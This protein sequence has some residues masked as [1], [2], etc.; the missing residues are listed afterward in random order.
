M[1]IQLAQISPRKIKLAH[2]IDF[3]LAQQPHF[4]RNRRAAQVLIQRGQGQIA[5]QG[6]FEIGGVVE[7]E[8]VASGEVEGC[9][10]GLLIGF[11]I[12]LN[13]KLCQVGQR[14][15]AKIGGVAFSSYSHLQNI[16]DFQTPESRNP[17]PALTEQIEYFLYGGGG[18][19]AVHPCHRDRTIE[20]QAHLGG[21]QVTAGLDHAVFLGPPS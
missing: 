16:G 19:V 4:L 8:L 11:A 12:H 15:V 5:P 2:G 13:G 1:W 7:S 14:C 18:F 17:A 3:S 21:P 6:Q 9:A 20:D 10:P